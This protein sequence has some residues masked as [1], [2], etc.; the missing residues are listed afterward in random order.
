[1][2]RALKGRHMTPTLFRPFRAR[3]VSWQ[4]SRGVAPG[5]HSL[6]RW[7]VRRAS[8][9]ALA[10][11]FITS[12][13]SAAEAPAWKAGVARKK[14]TPDQPLWMTGYAVRDHPAEG[15]AQELWVKALA[16]DDGAGH[17]A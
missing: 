10:L 6:P 7:G 12:I 2:N 14:I 16:L 9:A 4:I 5:C 8:V 13:A 15:V 11:L 17:R 3:V 1:M